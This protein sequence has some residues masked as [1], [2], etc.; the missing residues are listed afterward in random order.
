[1]FLNVYACASEYNTVI[2][3]IEIQLKDGRILTLNW[4]ESDNS[5]YERIYKGVH[6]SE[7]EESVSLGT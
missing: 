1:M 7:S 3:F 6:F 2:E 5:D 4:D